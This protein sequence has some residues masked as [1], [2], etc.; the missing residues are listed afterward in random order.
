MN[1]FTVINNNTISASYIHAECLTISFN[2]ALTA[3]VVLD[4]TRLD[5]VDELI[6]QEK[7]DTIN[8]DACFGF[9]IIHYMPRSIR[10]G[11]TA[12]MLTMS[13]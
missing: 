3:C 9:N 13:L 12:R 8:T 2:S 11:Y 1:L 6:A 5:G 10:F 4:A 7:S